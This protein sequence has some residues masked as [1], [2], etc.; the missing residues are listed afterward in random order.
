MLD[1]IARHDGTVAS[2][3]HVDVSGSLADA[4]EIDVDTSPIAGIPLAFKDIFAV[5][6]MPTTNNSRLP[7]THP[8]DDA[9]SVAALRD[10]GGIFLGK[11][12]AW[13]CG[14]GGTSFTLPWPPARNPWD[15]ACDPGGSSTGSAAAIAAGFCLGSLGSDTGG[16]IREPP[17]GAALRG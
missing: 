2:F 7:A 15:L 11:L 12:A 1:R 8:T 6:G 14:M 16:S 17:H 4:A 10:A 3:L 13:E 9:P 5:A